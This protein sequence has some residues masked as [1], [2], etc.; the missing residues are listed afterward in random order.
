MKNILKISSLVFIALLS[1]CNL[2]DLDRDLENPNE[3]GLATLDANLLMNQ[4]QLDFSEFISKSN[5][6]T[7]ELTRMMAQINGDVYARSYQAQNQDI[8]DAWQRAYQD[9]MVQLET[10]LATTDAQG[11]TRHSGAARVMKAYVM[12]TLVD[13][14][15]DVPYSEAVSG[16]SGNFNPKADNGKSIYDAAIATLDQAITN[17][18][19][20]PN[21][22]APTMRD[23]YYS[24]NATK[25]IACANTL[26]LKAYMNLSLTD[27]GVKSKIEEL[28]AADLIDTDAEEFTYKYS[29]ANVPA[30]S[31]HPQ[32]RDMY[33]PALGDSE[34]Y[35][36]NYFMLAAYKQKGVEDPRWRYYF[37]R[38]A[39]SIARML[40][41]DPKSLPCIISPRPSHY[42]PDQA[43]CAFDPG[44]Y[45]REHGN[46]DGTPPDAGVKTCVGV[47][48]SGGRADVNNGDN[49]YLG[50]TQQGQGADGA[51][52]LPIWMASFTEFV[53]AEAVVRLGVAGDAKAL[54][55]SGVG[56][57]IARVRGFATAKGQT[58]PAGLEPSESAYTD[59][60]TALYDAAAS[61]DER[62]SVIGKEYYLAL[63]GNGIESYNL[64]RRT[65]KPADIQ[66]MRA[67]S[68]GVFLRSL[69]YPA[70]Y[71]NLN[72]N[73]IQKD[74]NVV[75]KVFW[76]NNPD[77][78]VY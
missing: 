16:Q 54:M 34:T 74:L 62:M 77:N 36:G 4:V 32:Y 59:A 67:A 78:F 1:S 33:K 50:E 58:L 12:L 3:V 64:Y 41:Y 20:A 71:V 69:I 26:K 68:P 42:A 8:Q 48:P 70:D 45:G 6:P 43:W 56:K 14:W 63:W 21:G 60:V 24:G 37:Y 38:Q 40:Q 11:F 2:L 66:P 39:G 15:G 72:S 18:G 75:N 9:V 25:W 13:L 5:V 52:I 55:L 73:A 22:A 46:N 53:K 57:S 27:P 76:D 49:S 29:N 7:M 51:G 30:R 47:Y 28:L 65:G 10:L 17:L 23:V 35:L 61:D 31:R 44:F 19:T